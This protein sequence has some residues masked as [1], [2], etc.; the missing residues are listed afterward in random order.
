MWSVAHYGCDQA[1]A[2]HTTSSDDEDSNHDK[3][4]D[5]KD[6]NDDDVDGNSSYKPE[7]EPESD[8]DASA[9]EDDNSAHWYSDLIDAS[10]LEDY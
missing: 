9:G 3:S 7:L 1:L 6:D 8:D 2:T 5:A 10:L 4:H